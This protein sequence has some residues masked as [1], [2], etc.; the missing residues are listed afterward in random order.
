MSEYLPLDRF[1]KGEGDQP[2]QE[3]LLAVQNRLLDLEVKAALEA[4]IEEVGRIE[5]PRSD[6]YLGAKL[7]KEVVVAIDNNG[8]DHTKT[9]IVPPNRSNPDAKKF[10]LAFNVSGMAKERGKSSLGV[11]EDLADKLT[12][13]DSIRIAG[14]SGS[15]VNVEV[16][17]DELAPSIFNEVSRLGDRYGHFRDGQHQVVI[18]DYSSPNVAKN[19]TVAHLRSTIIGQSILKIEEAAGNVAFGINHIGDWGTQFGNIIY[20]YRKELT[21]RGSD[22]MN[23]LDDDPTATLMRIYRAFNERKD[24]DPEAVEAARDIF[25]SLE[26][27]DHELVQTWSQF[28]E[29]SLRDF[30][31]S[32]DRLRVKFDAIQGESFYEDRM[33]PAVEEAVARGVLKFNEE[34]AVVFPGQPLANPTTGKINDRVMLDHNGDIRDE[35]IVKPSGGTVYLT[36]DLAAIHYRGVELGADRVLY[37]IGKEQQTHCM[38][39]FSMADQLDYIPLGDAEHISFGHLNVDGR[40]MK[41]RE[42]K[43]VL[44]N[45][46]LDE[47]VS[48]AVRLLEDRKQERGDYSEL[49]PE[50]LEIARQV[51]TSALIFNDLK[52]N[53]EKDIEFDPDTART[54]EAGNA[55]Y[56]QYTNSRL[57]SIIYKVGSPEPVTDMPDN[58]DSSERIIL[59]EIMR[60]P[61]VIKEAASRKS[62]HKIASYLTEFCQVINLFYHERPIAKAS[63][64]IERNFRLNLVE[65]AR[66]VIKNASDLIHIEL[67]ERM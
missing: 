49:T 47:S 32:Y 22:F 59:T 56:V 48:A 65:S 45:D 35:I 23:E 34:G 67:P 8:F 66:Q 1:N 6:D 27:G 28:R 61:E 39:L 26:Q 57:N 63:S 19:M 33:T 46:I 18:V 13:E 42:G 44:L 50:E 41:S 60:F 37:V 20:E 7:K 31:P 21:E 10:D 29:W 43:V 62:P 58:I 36:R 25:L 55:A 15:F 17:Y 54:L 30:G 52:Q 4:K 40:K 16:N 5:L 38:E 3:N 14:S 12:Q 2:P 11:A 64:E 51:G 24:D 9:T 53:R